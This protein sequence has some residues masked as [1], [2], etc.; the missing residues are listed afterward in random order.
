VVQDVGPDDCPQAGIPERQLAGVDR[1]FHSWNRQHVRGAETGNHLCEESAAAQQA[2][3][4]AMEREA[5]FQLDQLRERNRYEERILESARNRAVAIRDAARSERDILNT[6]RQQIQLEQINSELARI[7]AY[8]RAGNAS[9]V[10][11]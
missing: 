8:A 10:N 4:D 9:G 3:I 2:M 6:N 11:P 7:A 5:Q 1:Q